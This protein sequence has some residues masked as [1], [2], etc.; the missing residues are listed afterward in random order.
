[1]T[2]GQKKEGEGK[3]GGISGGPR[4]SIPECNN[5][6]GDETNRKSGRKPKNWQTEVKV[7]KQRKRREKGMETAK[8]KMT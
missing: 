6:S 7:N 8:T 3:K 4:R 2:Q 1:M 5:Y